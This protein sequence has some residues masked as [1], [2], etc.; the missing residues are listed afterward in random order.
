MHSPSLPSLPSN[1]LYN[2]FPTLTLQGKAHGYLGG[3]SHVD[4]PAP[5]R[6]PQAP[7]TI[8]LFLIQVLVQ[9]ERFLEKKA[10]A[11]LGLRCL[12]IN[13]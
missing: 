12:G 7:T 13:N 9:A 1:Q 4:E 11:V 5:Q 3:I 10:Q 8:F 6:T 2:G